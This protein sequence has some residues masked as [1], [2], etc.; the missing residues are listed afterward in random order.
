M[1]QQKKRTNPN[2]ALTQSNLTTGHI[3]HHNFGMWSALLAFPP[4]LFYNP[5]VTHLVGLEEHRLV[6]VTL[7]ANGVLASLQSRVVYY[8]SLNDVQLVPG[9]D[10]RHYRKKHR[11]NS[12]E[13]FITLTL[14]PCGAIDQGSCAHNT[15]SSIFVDS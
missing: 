4:G 13:L 2:R 1:H 8:V 15:P 14:T 12:G 3:K 6:V 7:L 10:G 9:Q 11:A 5:R